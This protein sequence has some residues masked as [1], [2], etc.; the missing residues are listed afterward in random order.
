MIKKIIY[1][2]M[3]INDIIYN[4]NTHCVADVTN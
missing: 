2:I 4:N 1:N 3:I